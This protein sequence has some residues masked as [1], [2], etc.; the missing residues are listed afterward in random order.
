[1]K[2][3]VLITALTAVILAGATVPVNACTPS[4]KPVSSQ[5]WYKS[6]QNALNSAYKTGQNI[7]INVKIDSKYFEQGARH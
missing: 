2:K 4:Y 5:P 1:M 6:Y 7:M 3:K